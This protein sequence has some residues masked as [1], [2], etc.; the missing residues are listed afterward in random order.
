VIVVPW[1]LIP[2]RPY[3]IQVYLFACRLYSTDPGIGQRGVAKATRAQFKLEKFSH[4]TVSRSF[5]TLERTFKQDLERRFGEE[6]KIA[7]AGSIGLD[8]TIGLVD[9]AVKT[10]MDSADVPDTLQRFPS[11]T[12]TAGRRKAMADFFHECFCVAEEAKH[13]AAS[14]QFVKNWHIKTKRLLL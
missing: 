13:E 9:A 7:G 4:S 12:D 11:V 2:G 14:W 5:R 10:I 1:Y 3:P 8:G 6:V